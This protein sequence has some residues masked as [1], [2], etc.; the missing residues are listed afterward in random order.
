MSNLKS[1][2]EKLPVHTPKKISKSYKL[3]NKR[4]AAKANDLFVK[5]GE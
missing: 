4:K 1:D 2:A 3:R 5:G